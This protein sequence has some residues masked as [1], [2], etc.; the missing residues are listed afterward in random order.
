MLPTINNK[1]FLECSSSDLEILLDNS[2]YRENEYIDY[3]AN[4]SLLEVLKGE[5]NQKKIEFRNDI[6]AFANAEGG[7]LIYGI[8]DNNGCASK[9]IG[10]TI[11]NDDTDRFELDRRND[12][13]GIQPR[14]PYLKFHFIR[15][16]SQKYIVIIYVQHDRF[17]PYV[18]IEDEMNYK[19]YKRVGNGKRIITYT[20]LRAMFNHSYSL[21]TEIYN[22]RN[23]RINYYSKQSQSATD[24]F[25]KYLLFHIIPETFMDQEYNQNMFL[26]ERKKGRRLGLV[27]ASFNC[28]LDSIPCVDGLRFVSPSNGYSKAECYMNNNGC[29]ECFF[30]LTDRINKGQDRYPDGFIPWGDLW[31]KI[32]SVCDGYISIFKDSLSDHRLFFC[33]SIIGCKGVMS[34][35]PNTNWGYKGEIDRDVLLCQP[36]T[37][38]NSENTD[39]VMKRLEL[40]FLLSIGVKQNKELFGLINELYDQQ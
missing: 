4:F 11:E 24:H 12:L 33:I 19:V 14:V 38:F 3:K 27:F 22:F 28:C 25:A 29:A 39:I 34:E 16:E 10:I 13:T 7:Y 9:L 36:V 6:C 23:K 18:H 35:D 31:E 26:L 30:S 21:D 32:N 17:A 37:S 40:E 20:E 2:D 5:R 8:S 1:S 15:L